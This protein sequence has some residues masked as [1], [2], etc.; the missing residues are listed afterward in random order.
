MSLSMTSRLSR[1]FMVV[2]CAAV[3]VVALL[4]PA[5]VHA[6]GP[7][8]IEGE[9]T[10]TGAVPLAQ[11]WACAY[12]VQSEEFEENC[13]FTGASG[14]YSITGLKAG[15][16]KVEFWSEG[17][18]PSYVGEFYDDKPS[19]EEADGV[20]VEEGAVTTGIDAE[21][22]EGATVE[23]EVDAASVGG[24]VD[25]LV[26]A[27][28][29]TSEPVGCDRTRANGSY[30]LAGLPAGEYKIQFTP[31]FVGYNLLN[32]F[33]DHKSSW[34]E[35]DLL[36]L[37]AG[38]TRGG[39]DGDLEAGAEIHGTVYSAE[40]GSP[41]SRVYACALRPEEGEWWLRE[42]VPT[43]STG[44]YALHGLETD[45]Y[46]VVF[47]PELKEFFGEEILEK[48]DDGYFK[49]YFDNEPTLAVADTLALVPPEVRTGVDGHLQPEHPTSLPQTPLAS[50]AIAKPIHRHKAS[51]HCRPAFR[52][53]KVGGKRRCMRIHKHRR[54][55][56]Q[57]Q[58]G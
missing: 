15:E 49:Q 47:S 1:S 2:L 46:K 27:Q 9:V 32:Q 41:L 50:P 8:A 20:K 51:R 23:G 17:T 31:N 57:H 42:C 45:S 16:Y 11:V 48:E 12:L 36:A 40:S 37:V 26:C 44:S 53:K 5:V 52:K 14:I 55:G 34:V 18:E 22:A 54:H 21:L 58:N 6:A 19:W 38:E 13:D 25:A 30:T 3:A 43:S 24:P 10:T 39:I 28:L 33:Y 7:G 56:R 4:A 29:P 35:A